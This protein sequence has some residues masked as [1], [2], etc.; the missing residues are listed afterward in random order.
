MS[1]SSNKFVKFIKVFL[2]IIIVSCILAE[3]G[4]LLYRFVP[5]C[6]TFMDNI[7]QHIKPATAVVSA[8]EVGI[9]YALNLK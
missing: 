5:S 2:I 9:P 3:T 7:W 6:T 8:R 4:Y 1:G